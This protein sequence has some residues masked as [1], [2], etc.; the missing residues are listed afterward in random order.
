MDDVITKNSSILQH[1]NLH[2]NTKAFRKKE[3]KKKT[4]SSNS[5]QTFGPTR[6]MALH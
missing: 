5:F 1:I 2:D 6:I 3:I 4:F